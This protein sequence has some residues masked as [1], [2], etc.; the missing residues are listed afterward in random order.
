MPLAGHEGA[1]E[2]Q[3]DET[4]QAAHEEARAESEGMVTG[5]PGNQTP[6]ATPPITA[7]AAFTGAGTGK[8]PQLTKTEKDLAELDNIFTYHAPH[9]TQTMRY[10]HLR[11]MA[12]MFS[13]SIL[14]NCPPS[15]ERSLA[16]TSVQQTVMWANAGI[17]I[18][19]PAPEVSVFAQDLKVDRIARACHEAN[20]AYCQSLGDDSQAPWDDAPEWQKLS[21][22]LGVEAILRNPETTPE[23]SH[24]GW[25]QQKVADGWVYGAVKDPV[26]KT[27]P[28]LVPYTDLPAEQRMKD[29]LFGL[30]VRALA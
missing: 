1:V 8:R 25:F 27:H 29:V 17:A 9:G 5:Q 10:E 26:A 22:R 23:Q 3:T 4:T 12:K 21:A 13:R 24:I 11:T 19:E 6:G 30:V 15:R 20:R 2:T 16:L 14:N 28:C 7:G 18:N